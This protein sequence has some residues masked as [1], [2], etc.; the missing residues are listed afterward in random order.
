[1]K[2]ENFSNFTYSY[3]K[4]LKRNKSFL[5]IIQKR[6]H[7]LVKGTLDE[8]LGTNQNLAPELPAKRRNY[9]PRNNTVREYK[10]P[11]Y[12]KVGFLSSETN[13]NLPTKNDNS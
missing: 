1:M 12:S 6:R 13:F 5:P 7:K 11:D 2:D 8:F 3:S 10:K 9:V 4:G